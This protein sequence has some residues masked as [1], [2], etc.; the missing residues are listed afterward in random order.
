MAE[1]LERDRELDALG[2]LVAGLAEGGGCTVL[3][4]GEAG[5]GKTSLIR[6]LRDRS[7]GDSAF[8]IGACEPLSVPVPLGPLRE[9]AEAAGGEDP[10]AADGGDP[11]AVARHGF[12]ALAARAPAVAVIED[13]HWADPTTLDVIRLL[14]RR[15]EGSR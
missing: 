10:V 6:A 11:L 4:A 14:A 1:L 3:V 8:L 7:G 2:A 5:V 9:L 12:E 15:V 13:A